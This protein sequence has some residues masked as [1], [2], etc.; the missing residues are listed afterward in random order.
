M[1]K[2]ALAKGATDVTVNVFIQDASSEI[3]A[4]LTGLTFESASLTAYYVREKTAAT[5]IT[6]ATLA[7]VDSAYSDGGFK[8]IDAT[9]MPGMYRLD[10]PDAVCAVSSNSAA[11]ML[12]GASNMAP[13]TLEIQLTDFNL[14]DD[15]PG[16]DLTQIGGELVSGNNATLKLKQLHIVN[17]A[18]DAVYAKST[19]SNGAGMYLEGHNIGSGLWAKS[20]LGGNGS[21][22]LAHGLGTGG[23][24]LQIIASADA[25]SAMVVSAAGA[26]QSALELSGGAGGL[27]IEADEIAALSTHSAA[28]VKTAIE[29][30]GSHL[31]LILADTGTD[32]VVLANDAI[33]SAKFDES[34]AFPLKSADTGDTEVMRTGADGDTAEDLSDQLDALDVTVAASGRRVYVKQTT[35]R[36]S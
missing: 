36:G 33:T 3:G 18:G 2:L 23:V 12:K 13:L 34:T 35:V 6:L 19:G 30:A 7:A 27:D 4:G 8:E 28:D 15:T 24:G 5:E 10:L 26:N 25:G 11:V 14:N 20:G 16:V 21:G 29:A 31:A 32:G 17:T 9:N 1:A 22:I